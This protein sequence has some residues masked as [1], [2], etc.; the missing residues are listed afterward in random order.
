[1]DC[2]Q[3]DDCPGTGSVCVTGTG[4]QSGECFLGCAIGPELEFIDDPLS[5]NKCHGRED[6]RCIS[7]S[8]ADY[9]VPVCGKDSQC[10]GR[11]CD[12]RTSMCQDTANT[13]KANG[14]VC[15]ENASNEDGCAG[16]CQTFTDPTPSICTTACVLGGA[17]DGD[18]CNG[19]TNGLCIYRPGGYGAGDF[20]R[21]AAACTKHDQCGNPNWWCFGNNFLDF[22]G[23]NGFCFTADECTSGAQCDSDQYCVT[24]KHGKRCLEFNP[25][26][27]NSGSGGGGG[28]GGAGGAA[29]TY[30][31]ELLFPLGDAAP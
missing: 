16:F 25:S 4:E 3:N 9:C 26:M 14:T 15:N 10:E 12:P 13:G 30:P 17:L 23:G 21:C 28:A 31:C 29:P 27:C 20:G 11:V 24:T 18:D 22:T 1:M 8:S 5:A 2:L 19:L 6:V 7:T